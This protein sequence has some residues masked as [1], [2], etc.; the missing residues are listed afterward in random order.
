MIYFSNFFAHK[1]LR[2]IDHE[3]GLS[4]SSDTCRNV[5]IFMSGK[6]KNYA[7]LDTKKVE[8]LDTRNRT[9]WQNPEKCENLKNLQKSQK[10]AKSRKISKI[11]KKSRNREN[12]E[13]F[14]FLALW[15]L[16]YGSGQNRHP[17]ANLATLAGLSARSDFVSGD[18][19][20]GLSGDQKKCKNFDFL[21]PQKNRKFEL[22]AVEI[23]RRSPR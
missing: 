5:Q 17:E 4:W 3:S 23:D 21:T 18:Q 22:A 10:S 8:F 2:K 6:S 16:P 13:N 20:S 14:D 7:I 19:I 11:P 12:L 15:R 1:K 9:F